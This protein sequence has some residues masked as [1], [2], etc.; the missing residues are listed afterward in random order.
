MG[1][2]IGQIRA[3]R[4]GLGRDWIKARSECL[5]EEW[6]VQLSGDHK[7]RGAPSKRNWLQGAVEGRKGTGGRT[8]RWGLRPLTMSSKEP[9]VRLLPPWDR[10]GSTVSCMFPSWGVKGE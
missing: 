2:G 7:Q 10:S 1:A 3:W 9:S 6:R 4:G 5:T 8:L